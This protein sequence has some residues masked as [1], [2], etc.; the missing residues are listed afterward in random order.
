MG[1]NAARNVLLDT[2]VVPASTTLTQL[3]VAG[4]G[5]TKVV[6]SRSTLCAFVA[7]DLQFDRITEAVSS[8]AMSARWLL[9]LAVV[10][11]TVAVRRLAGRQRGA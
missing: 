7:D 10:L 1:G 5:I 9:L 6:L 4:A 8:P 3:S 2:A 11:A